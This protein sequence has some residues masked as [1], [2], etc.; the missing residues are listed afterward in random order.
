MKT[1]YMLSTLAL[2]FLSFSS[3]QAEEIK[4]AGT[5][6]S[7]T[8][9]F[10]PIK[11]VYETSTGDT[12]TLIDKHHAPDTL[13][14]LEKGEV[15]M[16]SINGLSFDDLIAEAHKAGVNINPATLQRTVVAK[17]N[18]LVFVN[19]SNAVKSLSKE[20]LKA[21]FTGKTTNWRDVGGANLAINV[22][23]GKGTPYLNGPFTSWVLDGEKVTSQAKS[24]GDHFD[25]REIVLK[26]QAAIVLSS[27]GLVTPLTN[28]PAIP[29]MHLPM[30]VVTK[31]EPSAKVKKEIG[32]AHV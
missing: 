14:S 29:P 19:K 11:T 10:S 9:L 27:S 22:Y 32:R 5:N 6:S 18:L 13:I 25:L 3:V 24:A 15:D 4:V 30:E 28:V 1:R 21:V 8:K 2:L 31:G 16:A 17:T 7:I 26:D 12:L 23:W 20:Q